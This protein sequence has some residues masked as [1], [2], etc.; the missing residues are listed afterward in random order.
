MILLLGPCLCLRS[1]MN[2]RCAFWGNSVLETRHLSNTESLILCMFMTSHMLFCRNTRVLALRLAPVVQAWMDGKMCLKLGRCRLIHP[3][4]CPPKRDKGTALSQYRLQ[5]S[6]AQKSLLEVM[7]HVWRPQKG[8]MNQQQS[9]QGKIYWCVL[10]YQEFFAKR[11]LCWRSWGWSLILLTR[12]TRSIKR[13]TLLCMQ[14]GVHEDLIGNSS[15]LAKSASFTSIWATTAFS[16]ATDVCAISK[17]CSV[18]SEYC[19]YC[20]TLTL[21][22]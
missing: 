19:W 11:L 22:F 3:L 9:L 2:L 7:M 13:T 10:V 12:S 17:F 21:N 6:Y 15:R 16:I 8:E 4:L 14:E 20:L 18:Q 5:G 1:I